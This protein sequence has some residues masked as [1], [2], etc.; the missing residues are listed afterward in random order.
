MS[1]VLNLTLISSPLQIDLKGFLL[2]SM[3]AWLLSS[4]SILYSSL[5]YAEEKQLNIYMWEDT[6]SPNV[7]SDWE[8]ISGTSLNLSHF[9]NDDERSLLMIKSVQLPFDLVILDNVSAQIYGHLGAFEDLSTLKNRANNDPKWNQ[10]C[11]PYAVPYFWGTVGIA[12]RKDIIAKPPNT[13]QEFVHPPDNLVGKIGMINDSVESLLPV[14]YSL[15]IPPTT[16]DPQQ[17]QAAYQQMMQFSD[18]VLSYEYILSYIRSQ[19]NLDQ[20][21]MALAYSGDHY[22]LNRYFNQDKWGYVIPEG[23]L[24]VWVDC[25]AVTSHSEQKQTAFALLEYLMS[26][27]VAAKNAIDIK[28][29][30]P[31]LKATKLLPDWY[32]NDASL[33]PPTERLNNSRIDSELS[34]QNISLRAKIINQMLKRHEAKH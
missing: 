9:D 19:K 33:F 32:L 23:E 16:D 18:K 25:L 30:T 11:G 14:L 13:W 12:Y 5:A 4:L 27:K 26:P 10:A 1:A 29:A 20:I 7:Q 3:R 34:A 8:R 31:N 6:L 17:L 24:F 22:S 28:A 15:G 21:Q 2:V